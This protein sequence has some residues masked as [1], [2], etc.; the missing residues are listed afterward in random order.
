M[1]EN[2]KHDRAGAR[3]GLELD[4]F[5]SRL[6]G[7]STSLISDEVKSDDKWRGSD[8]LW[9]V[10]ARALAFIASPRSLLLS[11]AGFQLLRV[12]YL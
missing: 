9:L 5:T 4:C 2:I 8:R 3:T 7:V 6:L 11:T 12:I 10:R 1:R